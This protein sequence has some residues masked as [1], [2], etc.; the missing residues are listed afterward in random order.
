MSDVIKIAQ[1]H[2]RNRIR[3]EPIAPVMR[4]ERGEEEAEDDDEQADRMF[5]PMPLPGDP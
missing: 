1:C 2:S 5:I 4:D 3:D